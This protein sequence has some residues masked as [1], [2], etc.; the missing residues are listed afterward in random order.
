MSELKL[1]FLFGKLDGLQLCKTVTL[2]GRF[3]TNKRKLS[4]SI[5]GG[6]VGFW[7]L[8]YYTWGRMS[9]AWMPTMC[10]PER[11]VLCY[12]YCREPRLFSIFSVIILCLINAS[13]LPVRH[14][15]LA[16]GPALRTTKLL[17]LGPDE[18]SQ[19]AHHVRSRKMRFVLLSCYREP[20]L[21]SF[22]RYN[23][24]LDV[25]SKWECS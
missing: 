19:D 13:E 2:D 9:E 17:H 8:S 11:W 20:R 25:N 23:I 16:P 24:I 10:D 21:F 6:R 4:K 5:K 15:W 18:W 12:F 22:F 7:F 3:S 14:D 1:Y